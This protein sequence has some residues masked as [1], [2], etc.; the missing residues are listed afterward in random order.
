LQGWRL[1]SAIRSLPLRLKA[2]AMAHSGQPVFSWSVSNAKVEVGR[3]NLYMTKAH[4]GV[5]KID[6]VIALLNA[7]MLMIN[8]PEA[9]GEDSVLL[10]MDEVVI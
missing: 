10:D 1:Q 5:A 7:A 4:A 6:V 2:D 9:R 3:N 8:N